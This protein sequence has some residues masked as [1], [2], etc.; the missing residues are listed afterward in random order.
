MQCQSRTQTRR[1]SQ[2]GRMLSGADS[3]ATVH[4]VVRNGKLRNGKAAQYL[5]CGRPVF[6]GWEGEKPITVTWRLPVPVPGHLRPG[7]G[8]AG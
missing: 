5:Y 3:Q 4:L 7:L 6:K 8:I 2:I 1:D